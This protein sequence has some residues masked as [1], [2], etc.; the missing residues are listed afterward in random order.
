MPWLV[1]STSPLVPQA[2]ALSLGYPLKAHYQWLPSLPKMTLNTTWQTIWILTMWKKNAQLLKLY[3]ACTFYPNPNKRQNSTKTL[4]ISSLSVCLFVYWLILYSLKDIPLKT[5]ADD[6][7]DEYLDA[8]MMLEGHGSHFQPCMGC[9]Y[10]MPQYWCKDCTLGPL[11]CKDCLVERHGQSP[12][13]LVEVCLTVISLS[14]CIHS[15]H[16]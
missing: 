4:C 12:L 6:F 10:P 5:W 16:V 1:S 15:G 8:C 9:Q 13:H 2:V 7:R 14:Y 11:W 3:Q